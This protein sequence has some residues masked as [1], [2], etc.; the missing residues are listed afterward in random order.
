MLLDILTIG[1]AV[2][3]LAAALELDARCKQDT[4]KDVLPK[5]ATIEK[6]ASVE[7][8]GE[9]GEGKDNIPYPYNPKDLPELCAVTVK[10]NSSRKSAYRF[11]L[12]L[13]TEWNSKILTVGNGG[14]AGGIN[15][16]DM[17]AGVHYGFASTSTDTG[18]N[19]SVTDLEWAYQ[20][21]ET[22]IDWGW[23]A[24]HGTVEL[25]RKMTAQYYDGDVKRSYYSGC[26]TGGRQGL[27]E[28]QKFPKSFD[29]VLVG[30]P[31]WNPPILNTF[32]TQIGIY[33]LPNNTEHHI[34]ST[35]FKTIGAEVA[36]QCDELDG[37]KDGIVS[38]P[39]ECHPDWTKIGCDIK[40]INQSECLHP[41]QM[42]TL[43]NMYKGFKSEDGKTTLWPGFLPSAEAQFNTV[44][45]DQEPTPFGVQFNRYFVYDR[46]D[47]QWRDFNKSAVTTATKKNPGDSR[48]DK[49]DLSEFRDRGG[50]IVMYHGMADGLVTIQGTNMY[51]DRVVDKMG[52]RPDDFFRYFKVPGMQHCYSTVVN[53]P[54]NFAGA[55]QAGSLGN[56]TWS[57]PNF[58]DAEHDMLMALMKW[59]EEDKPVDSVIATTWETTTNASTP[60]L[61]QRPLCPVPQQAVYNEEGDVNKADSWQCK[62]VRNGETDTGDKDGKTGSTDDG[63]EDAAASF[64]PSAI[65]VAVAIALCTLLLWN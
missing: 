48:A 47:W 1:L 50:K 32:V 10:V 43:E 44:L 52:G 55:F 11:G 14:F 16:L 37:V 63:D 18:H 41:E 25:G 57:V 23:R 17:G 28:M 30:A 45:R 31:A 8:G 2:S 22:R 20:N 12:F 9:Y 29:G 34:N 21:E 46:P 49:Y 35:L 39:E 15:W 40:G 7:K 61:R 24:I 19:S 26:S 5:E 38:A 59:V 6:L 33:N 56:D 51:F 3:G 65:L 42:K 36:K 27:K 13:P 54:W 4:F 53:A 58:Q 64:R 60:V 62:D